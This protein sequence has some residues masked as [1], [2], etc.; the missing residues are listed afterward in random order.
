MSAHVKTD[1]MPKLALLAGGLA[2]RLGPV[3]ESVA[4]SMVPVAGE[5]FIAHQLRL[6]SSQGIIDIVLC[7][8]H[9][10]GQIQDFVGNGSKFGCRVEYSNDGT[11]LLGTGGAIKKALPALGERFLVMYGDSY[12][13]APMQPVWNTFVTSSK[14]ALMTIF[15]NEGRWDTS[16]ISFDGKRILRYS[17]RAPSPT[18]QHIDYGL[19]CFRREAFASFSQY[20][21]FDLADV[22]GRLAELGQLDGYEV[23]ERFYEI[24]SPSGL[25]EADVMLQIQYASEQK[26]QAVAR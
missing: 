4:K 22:Y 2:T 3:T 6:L 17:K 12:L 11:T 15:H 5:P 24:G 23:M 13:P 19:G 16:N 1:K 25:R 21:R 20:S 7:C 26:K 18:M 14:L 10:R 9:L 8:A